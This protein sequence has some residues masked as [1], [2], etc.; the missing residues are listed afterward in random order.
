V[1]AIPQQVLVP[2]AAITDTGEISVY[3]TVLQTV[4]VEVVI[5]IVVTVSAVLVI[6]GVRRAI[7]YVHETVIEVCVIEAMETVAMAV[8]RDGTG[9]DVRTPVVQT[10]L[11]ELVI[12]NREVVTEDVKQT[13]PETSVTV[14]SLSM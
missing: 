3:F 12:N 6:I 8:H 5:G 7:S 1:H 9:I 13:G 10:V 2:K 11:G 4:K 14:S